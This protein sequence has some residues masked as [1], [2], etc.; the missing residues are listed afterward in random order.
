MGLQRNIKNYY[1]YSLWSEALIIGPVIM[2]YLLH[3][4]GLS[5]TQAMFLSSASAISLAVLE[6]P[7]GVVADKLGR[8][9]S[10]LFGALLL[11]LSM[12]VYVF[13][14]SFLL[15]MVAEMIFALG[16][17]FKSGADTALLYDSLVAIGRES[18]F[19]DIEGRARARVFWVQAVGSV[20]AGFVYKEYVHLPMLLSAGFMLLT[21]LVVL[22]FTEPPVMDE[23]GEEAAK[24]SYAAQVVESGRYILRHE[25]IKALLLYSVVFYVF[26]RFG[27]FLFQPYMNSV[28]LPVEYMGVMFFIFNVVA[29]ITSKNCNRIMKVTRRRTLTFMS[30]LLIISFVMLGLTKHWLGAFLI[31]PQQI[32]RGLYRPVTRKYFNKYIPGD[33]R[34]TILSFISLSTS[35]AGAISYPLLGLLR[36]ATEIHMTHLVL[37]VTMV[38]MTAGTLLYMRSRIGTK[39]TAQAADSAQLLKKRRAWGKYVEDKSL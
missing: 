13:A 30:S 5:F 9:A 27:F 17:A 31:L 3:V 32:A 18:E 36:D 19:Q 23:S 38:A 29:A 12:I 33:K 1:R 16:W 14:T 11:S 39:H 7:T 6:V 20:V 26:Y 25:K 4:K 28:G 35:L 8:K 10:L 22:S 24:R 2:L 21:A 15:C 37:A 34:A